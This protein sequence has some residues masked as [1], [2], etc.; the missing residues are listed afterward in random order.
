MKR[1][2]TFMT[3]LLVC[4]CLQAQNPGGAG[5][6]QNA[7]KE[8][9]PELYMKTLNDFVTREAKLTEAESAKFFPLLTEMFDKQRKIMGEQRDLMMKTWK[10]AN[11]SEADY[12]NIVT[13]LAGLE[14]ESRKVE[15]TYYKKFHTVLPWKKV[16]AVRMALSRFQMEALNHFQPGRGNNNMNNRFNNSPRWNG[17]NNGNRK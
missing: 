8:F 15:Q 11:L 7:R 10:N 3:I 13:K 17:W 16:F 14:V 4:V 9:S 1:I 5:K 2:I 12:E 6:N